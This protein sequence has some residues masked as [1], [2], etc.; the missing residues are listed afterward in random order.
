MAVTKNPS[1]SI[2]PKR[3]LNPAGQTLSNWVKRR[4]GVSLLVTMLILIYVSPPQL[5]V[6][7]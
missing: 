2:A 1:Y 5:A 7:V 4:G 6:A 3:R